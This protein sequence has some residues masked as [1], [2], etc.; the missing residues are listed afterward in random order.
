M[1][2]LHKSEYLG[3]LWFIPLVLLIAIFGW[4]GV[5]L[6]LIKPYPKG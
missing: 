5:K 2:K 4:I 6:R 1:S 3:A